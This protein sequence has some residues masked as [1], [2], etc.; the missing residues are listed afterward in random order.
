ML[1]TRQAVF[2]MLEM[3]DAVNYLVHPQWREQDFAWFRATWVECAELLD[4][5][6]YK[7]WKKQQPDMAQVQLEVVDIWHFGLSALLQ[8]GD[9]L[10]VLAD[11]V[12]LELDAGLLAPAQALPD[13]VERL[14]LHV[15]GTRGFPVPD[16]GV[17]MHAAGLDVA[18]LYRAYVGK[19]V[20]NRLRQD[21]GYQRGEYRKVWAGRED[22]LH[23]QEL[24]ES[25]DCSDPAFPEALHSALLT[26]YRDS[27]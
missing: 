19:N 18:S 8:P 21:E 17:L 22:N 27:T 1:S 6:G 10:D 16:F 5:Y 12:S 24:L 13:A 4:H 9:A 20:L 7:W 3:Q 14:A 2:T 23:L 25:L 11:R 15:L 26:R